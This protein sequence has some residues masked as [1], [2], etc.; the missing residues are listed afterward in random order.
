M[1]GEP[2]IELKDVHT[3]FGAHVVHQ[4]LSLQVR[5]AE[6]FALVGGSGSGKSTLL[7]EMI[8]LHPPDAG[9]ISV[10]GVD[11]TTADAA[12]KL[13]LRQRLLSFGLILA[14]GFLLTVSLVLSAGLATLQRWWNPMF[15]PWLES[16]ALVN[17]VV[18]FALVAAM[19]AGVYKVMPRA[20]VA[21][22]DVW[23]GALFTA[24]LFTL[25]KMAIGWYVGRSGAV[26][27]FGA[28]GSLVVVLLWVYWSAQ[29][30]LLGA[31]E[32][33]V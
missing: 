3:R 20:N 5:R 31:S 6:I 33:S 13:A 10:L 9:R 14:I 22:R 27:G 1:N 26:S 8:L 19:F 7:R 24:V 18:G 17:A 11:L 4:G 30:F 25:G 12:A 21:W 29:I 32:N 15:G 16:A 2:V 23:T 28:A